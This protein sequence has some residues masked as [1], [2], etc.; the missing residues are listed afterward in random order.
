MSDVKR[1]I[2]YQLYDAAK[3]L[4][5]L[6]E[7]RK[8]VVLATDY[9]A[10]TARAEQAEADRA[11]MVKAISLAHRWIC[12]DSGGKDVKQETIIKE[13][14]KCL[15]QPHPGSRLL[16]LR[17]IV[18]GLP[19]D[20]GINVASDHTIEIRLDGDKGM[21]YAEK[22]ADALARLLAWREQP[23]ERSRATRI[24]RSHENADRS[25]RRGDQD[26]R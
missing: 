6:P 14:H 26:P 20:A 12:P 8:Q 22:C 21:K 15:D 3:N 17:E 23:Y 4:E 24:T 10:A 25:S 19:K 1:Y 9:D 18:E 16:E 5:P 2:A 7:G 13:L 11:A